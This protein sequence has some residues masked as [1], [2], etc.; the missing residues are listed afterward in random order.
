MNNC[1]ELFFLNKLDSIPIIER[2]RVHM[3]SI[4]VEMKSLSA[5]PCISSRLCNKE[6]REIQIRLAQWNL[7]FRQIKNE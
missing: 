3:Q 1:C 2:Q 6:D 7:Q 5:Q 4:L